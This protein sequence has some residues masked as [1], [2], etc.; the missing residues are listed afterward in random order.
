[1]PSAKLRHEKESFESL[2]RRF[3]RNVDK[4][5]V[6]QEVRNR[7]F[8]EKPSVTRKRNKAAAKKRNQRRVQEANEAMLPKSKRT[9]GRGKKK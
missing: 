4:D 8:Y 7:E 6:I 5:G 1:M 3:K 9:G 2:M